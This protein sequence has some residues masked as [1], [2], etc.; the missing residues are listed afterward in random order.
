MTE[1]SYW[2]E[3]ERYF[4]KKRGNALIPASFAVDADMVRMLEARLQAQKQ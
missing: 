1:H 4:V 2:E 3:I